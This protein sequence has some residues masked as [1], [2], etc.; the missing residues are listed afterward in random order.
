VCAQYSKILGSIGCG[1]LL[2]KYVY[3]LDYQQ[4]GGGGGEPEDSAEDARSGPGPA[5][6]CQQ[7]TPYRDGKVGAPKNSKNLERLSY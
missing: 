7:R 6:S 1:C 4:L 2:Y 5:A 3:G